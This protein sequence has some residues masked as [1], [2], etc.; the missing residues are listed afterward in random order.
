MVSCFKNIAETSNPVSAICVNEA[1]FDLVQFSLNI[2]SDVY[3]NIPSLVAIATEAVV[4]VEVVAVVVIVV[5]M[6]AIVVVALVA[7]V[8]KYLFFAQL[9]FSFIISWKF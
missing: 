3:F 8:Y 2:F 6:V 5:V 7:V 4:L 9:I 1:C